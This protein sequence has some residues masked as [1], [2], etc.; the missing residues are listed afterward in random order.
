VEAKIMDNWDVAL[1]VIA[2]FAAVVGLVR[3]MNR[4]R[5]QLADELLDEAAHRRRR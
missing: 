3:L 4:R 5:D 2:S 1:A